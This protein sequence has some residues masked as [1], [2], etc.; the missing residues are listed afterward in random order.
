MST[1][2]TIAQALSCENPRCTCGKKSGDGFKGHCP[3]HQDG[4]PSLH[5][6]EKDGKLLVKC[7]GGCSQET[8]LQALRELN[9]WP[10]MKNGEKAPGN[11]RNR[12]TVAIKPNKN[13]KLSAATHGQPAC[14]PA[15]GLTLAELATAKKI[16]PE[17][18]QKCGVADLKTQGTARVKIPYMNEAGEVVAVRY[19]HTLSGAQRFT[20]RKGDKVLLYGLWRLAEIKKAGWVLL[21]E[22]ES[23][24]WTC[25][26]FGIPA[27]GIPGKSTW[28][29]E[30]GEHFKGLKVL[31]W[32]EP[33]APEFPAKVA[34]DIPDLMVISAPNAFKD[35]SAAHLKG[36]TL[37]ALIEQLKAYATPAATILKAQKDKRLLELQEAA[38]PVMEDPD[39]L[40]L[41]E[42][43]VKALGYGGDPAP[44]LITYLAATSRLLEMRHGAMPVH[45][46]LV[47]QA[48]AGKTYTLTIVLRL[49]PEEA[50]HTIPAGSPRVL[51]YDDA[52][53]Q[54]RVV[55]F[56]EADSLPAGEDNPAAS[57]IRNLLQ[58]HELHYDVTVKDPNTGDYIVKKVRKPG[59]SVLMTTSTRRLGHQ[60][61]TR[62]FSLEAKDDPGHLKSALSAQAA[63]E[64]A[65][66]IPK[67]DPV[68][69]AFQTYLQHMAPWRVMVP[70]AEEL[71]REIGMQSMAPRIL[72]DFQKLLSFIKAVAILRHRRRSQDAHGRIMATL[73]DYETVRRLVAPVYESTISGA[74]ER[75][76]ETVRAV[77]DIGEETTGN[78]IAKHLKINK[79]TALRRLRVAI[80]EGWLIN[81]E[82]RK[83]Y[84]A[85]LKLGDPLPER[86]GLPTPERLQGSEAVAEKV[87]GE[88]TTE[89]LKNTDNMG[90]GC[91]VAGDTG[92]VKKSTEDLLRGEA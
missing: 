61:D 15:P 21:V 50:F 74:S 5:L 54:H 83:G 59:P 75:V 63:L 82:T 49:L 81:T 66:R 18:L 64:V 73:E 24:C 79:S 36:E 43:Q 20:W 67:P 65:E 52:D 25:W 31:L 37:P 70:F 58:D 34:R 69:I 51:I 26:L 55:V 16:P 71:A 30:W 13:N 42:R 3:A 35:L 85:S 80:K 47:A 76:R 46:L 53:L 9:L 1:A 72:R 88:A 14:N 38:R 32:Q 8:V 56:G 87:P 60:L 29:S 86:I 23:D 40:A 28:R 39:P 45:L 77:A 84:P 10:T 57:A 89:P 19:R 27:L 6:T 62:I 91:T 48:S 4:T 68:L 92:G 7:F 11:G 12:A 22:G 44:A 33:D 78:D 17:F 41:V 90:S 2:K